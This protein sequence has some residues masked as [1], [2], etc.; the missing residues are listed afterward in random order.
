VLTRKPVIPSQA[1]VAAN[2]RARSAKLRV[3]ERLRPD[4]DLDRVQDA[5][6]AGQLSAD[7]TLPSVP[8]DNI[9]PAPGLRRMNVHPTDARRAE[10]QV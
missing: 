8:P 6:E 5:P 4:A 3:A 9:T 10:G 2:P 1:E 7:P